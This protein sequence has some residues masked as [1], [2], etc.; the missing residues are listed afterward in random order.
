[1]NYASLL[2]APL[3]LAPVDASN[4]GPRP[5][6]RQP[7]I[8]SRVAPILTIAG[9]RFRDLNKNGRLDRYEDWRLPV[10]QRIDDLVAKMTVAEKAGLMMFAS[11]SGFVGPN[12]TLREELAPLPPGALKSPV[13]VTGVP[14]FDRADKPSPR[15]LLLEKH[16][17]WMAVSA[18]GKPGDAARWANNMQAL[19]EQDRLG[20]P[21]VLAADPIHTT[22]R[23]PGGSLPPPDRVKITSDWPD[24][25]GLA[26]I[27]DAALV[28]RFGRIGAAEYRAIGLR[29]VINPMVDVATEPRWNRIPGTFGEDAALAARLGA[30]YVRGF[31]GARIG[32]NS[33]LTI[34]KHFPGDGPVENGIDPHNVYGQRFVYPARNLAYHLEPFKAGIAAGAT[35]VMTAYG[36]PTGIDTVGS[37]FS[38]RVVT[39]MLRGDLGFN[40]I[41]VTDW[42]HAQPWGVENLSKRDRQ[43]RMIKAGVD[44]F[45]GEH[46][47]EYVIELVKLGRVSQARL[48][49]SARRIL[50]PMFELGLFENPYVDAEA[51]D[52]ILNAPAYAAA[53]M[54]AQRRAIV[55]LK[56]QAA[57]LPLAPAAKLSLKGFDKP[58]AAF[59]ARLA[60]SDATADAIVVK[61]NAPYR[62]NETGKA[63]FKGTHEGPVSF[64]GADNESD[65]HAIRAAVKTGKPVIVVIS[66]ERPSVLSEFIDGV[67][68]VV[69]TFGSGDAAVA[70]ILTGR[71][72]PTGN[73]PF[74]LPA[75]DVSVATQH[76]DAPHDFARTAF[77]QGFGLTYDK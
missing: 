58:P 75:D 41:V 76:E 39:D 66:M 33:V 18:G 40:G 23:L 67:G 72:R 14:G 53:A 42:L 70:D 69:A 52:A 54:D 7:A 27:G 19:A 31:Q 25:I 45:G 59:A 71:A 56:N 1:M 35:G 74:D 24:Q 50:K 51:A 57:T 77:R 68:A 16:V 21:V 6:Q 5:A 60:A 55:L 20:I 44:Q 47:T 3:L 2:L 8:E 65:L 11:H 15:V 26:A 10:A 37:S 32:S 46:E 49:Q 63:F 22:N 38:K 13:N 28:E 9:K 29:M 30:A 4:A 48:D 12:G 43:G 64:V 36:I 61:V 62:V 34:I 17:R 73:L